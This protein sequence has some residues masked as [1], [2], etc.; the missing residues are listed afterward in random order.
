MQPAGSK[1]PAWTTNYACLFRAVRMHQRG[2]TLIRELT[3]LFG[4]KVGKLAGQNA[5]IQG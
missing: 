1:K 3:K 2:L 5:K 4:K